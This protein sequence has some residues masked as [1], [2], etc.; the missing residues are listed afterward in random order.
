MEAIMDSGRTTREFEAKLRV[1]ST[2]EPRRDNDYFRKA[3]DVLPAAVYAT[4]ARGRIIYF[5]EAA[6]EL[7]GCR[8]EIGQTEW[9]GFWKL[10]W[11]DGTF[12]P[13]SECPMAMAIKENRPIRGTEAVAERPDGSRVP[14]VPF[15]TPLHD[16]QGRLIGAVNLVIDI[17]DRKRAEQHVQR[18]AS[19]VDSS[20]DAII[21]KDLNGTI[22]SWNRGAERLFGYSAE[23]A[24]GQ[25][26]T[27][28]VPE[29]RLDEDSGNLDRLR[30]GERVDHYDTIRQ[31]KDGSLVDISLAVSPVKD[32]AGRVVGASKI[33]R[34]ITERKRAQAQ[35]NLVLSE[36]RHRI[37]NTLATVQA[38]A[39]QTFRSA[40]AEER[41]T[42]NARL[43]LLAAA[44]D[45]LSSERW[46]RASMTDVI[47]GALQPFQEDRRERFLINGPSNVFLD[48]KQS[49][50]IA[51]MLHELA[52]NA[53][54]YG[55]LSNPKGRISVQWAWVQTA[56]PA[57]V[58][59]HWKE[60]GGP[61]V[62]QPTRRGFGSRL[63]EQTI[64][65]ESAKTHV[66]YNPRGVECVL[67]VDL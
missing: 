47:G 43:N 45:L 31:R 35:N 2:D 33:A 39:N 9:C 61:P 59:L 57:R 25:S 42:F 27:V 21:D 64:I 40:S 36:M 56:N 54:K 7:F 30:R 6:A 66:D 18:I 13:H 65:G 50:G 37:K 46:N 15:P 55:A 23:E 22:L 1:R 5:N 10:Y 44:Y 14:V 62:A 63:I 32:A 3:L 48:S 19:I 17:S 51:M 16:E 24:L 28:L 34:D 26:I 29:D 38:I 53:V 52:T 11:P 67:E 49:L 4:D 58:K 12:L 20:E 60:R 41:S 8:P